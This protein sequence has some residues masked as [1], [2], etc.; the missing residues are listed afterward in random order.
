VLTSYH[1]VQKDATIDEDDFE[2]VPAT[3][4]DDDVDM[5]DAENKDEDKI[6]QAHI[7]GMH[8]VAH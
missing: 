5:W 2:V 3:V 7:K 8:T 6:K 1:V 4:S